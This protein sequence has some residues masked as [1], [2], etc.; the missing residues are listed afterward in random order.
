M[1]RSMATV[2][3]H[4]TLSGTFTVCGHA[5]QFFPRPSPWK[6]L[7]LGDRER[8][9]SHLG[10][11]GMFSWVGKLQGPSSAQQRQWGRKAS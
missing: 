11:A 9:G 8:E 5:E 3:L 1:K 7:G 2:P 10:T 6:H 4:I